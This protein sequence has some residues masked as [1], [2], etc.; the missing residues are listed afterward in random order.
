MLK[1]TNLTSV[2][3]AQ[4]PNASQNIQHGPNKLPIKYCCSTIG[5]NFFLQIWYQKFWP[6]LG[7]FFGRIVL[8]WLVLMKVC[9]IR[10]HCPAVIC[11]TVD[12][13][14]LVVKTTTNIDHVINV[15]K[16]WSGK[17]KLALNGDWSQNMLTSSIW[18]KDLNFSD[19]IASNNQGHKS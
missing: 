3:G 16:D 19:L 5:A 4:H 6:G 17:S 18:G 11:K 10:V 8:A 13:T 7:L 14:M 9:C 1:M 12:P 15:G 2:W